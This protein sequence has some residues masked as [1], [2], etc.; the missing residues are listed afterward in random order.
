MI[1]KMCQINLVILSDNVGSDVGKILGFEANGQ[2]R[3]L[4]TFFVQ[5][6]SFIK[7]WVHDPWAERAALGW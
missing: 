3:I 7:T 6:G 4:A 5:K 2:E 1:A